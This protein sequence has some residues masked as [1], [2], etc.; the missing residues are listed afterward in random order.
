VIFK[1][2]SAFAIRFR[3]F[4]LAILEPLDEVYL[5]EASK[6]LPA[7]LRDKLSLM[8]KADKKH[9]CRLHKKITAAKFLSDEERAHLQKTALL[10]DIGKYNNHRS[11]LKK[12]ADILLRRS[13]SLHCITGYNLLKKYD[14]FEVYAREAL[15][16]NSK[17]PPTE[18]LAIFQRFDDAS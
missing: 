14:G 11:L 10:H 2:L 13:K 8:S 4:S 5:M 17:V 18:L 16:H 1:I 15:M 3:Q 7:D 9:L 6:G 12:V